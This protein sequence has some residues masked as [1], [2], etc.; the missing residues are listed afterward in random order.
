[1]AMRLQKLGAT[2]TGQRAAS[3]RLSLR[4]VAQALLAG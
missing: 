1:M 3:A 2:T 4:P